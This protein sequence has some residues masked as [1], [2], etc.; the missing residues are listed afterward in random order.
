MTREISSGNNNK[1]TNEQNSW[2]VKG[3]NGCIFSQ[4]IASNVEKYNWQKTIVGPLDGNSTN[5]IDI[6]VKTAIEDPE[7]RL[8]SLIFPAI[9]SV[10]DLS[11]LCEILSIMTQTIF[12]LEDNYVDGLVALS[13]RASLEN[14][15][16]LGWI[17][18]FGPYDFFAETRQ[19]PY[20]ELV[21]PVKKKPDNTYHRHNQ[22][23]SSA[24]VADQHIPLDDKVLDR[25]WV[26]TFKK[27][28]KILGHKPNIFSGARTTVVLPENQWQKKVPTN[29]TNLTSSYKE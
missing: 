11:H 4:V 1:I 28:E 5:Q 21:I 25:I 26:N 18:G 22:D 16:V 29:N 27:T 23:K 8:L 2:H 9:E 13:F 10:E 6:S 14:G 20:T 12:L 24:H 7:V 15:E 19:A 3:N 17:M